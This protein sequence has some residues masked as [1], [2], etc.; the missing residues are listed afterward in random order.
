MTEDE[1]RELCPQ[2]D[3]VTIMGDTIGLK[4]GEFSQ[5]INL[6]YGKDPTSVSRQVKHLY[7][8]LLAMNRQHQK[9]VDE[10]IKNARNIR[11]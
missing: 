5:A 4:V 8:D 10:A 6:V 7:T 11:R 9:Q 3:R 2:A 1:I